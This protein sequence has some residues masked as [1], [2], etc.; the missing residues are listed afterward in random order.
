[1]SEEKLSVKKLSP[2]STKKKKKNQ[3]IKHTNKKNKQSTARAKTY[4]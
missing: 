4:D 2:A 3:Q 1:M